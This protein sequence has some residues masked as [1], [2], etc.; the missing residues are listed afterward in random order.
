M[1]IAIL[2][3]GGLVGRHLAAELGGGARALDRAA[4]D[5]ANYD[6]VVARTA[7]AEAIVN[8][9]AFTDVDGAEAR[10]DDAFRANA[11]G[12]EN[13]ARAAA[14][15]GAVLM[16]L[17]TDFIF[18]G[19]QD[20]FL[21]ENAPPD[22]RSVYARSKLEGEQRVSKIFK[23][24]REKL[25]LVRVQALYGAGGRG[26]SSRLPSLIRER[27][28]LALDAERRVQPTSARAAARQLV[29]LLQSGAYGTYPVSCHGETTWAGFARAV[30]ERF[31]VAP[32][33]REVATAEL[34]APAARPRNCLFEHRNLRARGLDVL[35]DWRAALDEFLAEIS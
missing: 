19:D 21:D 6:E 14:H 5:I 3:A 30:A 35:P 24:A 2:G 13:V 16:H 11:L 9:A 15:H 32:A 1:T 10:S 22:P 12:A 20:G 7:G 17:S 33:W 25:F 34:R 27:R 4:C 28:A 23:T 26:F 29:K 18:G 8:C 31:G